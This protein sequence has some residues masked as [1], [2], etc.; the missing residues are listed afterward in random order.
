MALER[1]DETH[2]LRAIE[3]AHQSRANGNHPFGAL[4]VAASARVVVEAENTALTE[5]VTGHAEL[6]VVRAASKQLDFASMEGAT[7]YASTEPCAMCSGAIYWSGV[8]RV[9][10]A[11]SAET[12]MTFVNDLSGSATLA[13]PCREIFARGGR[14]VEVS[15]PHLVDQASAVHK[16]YWS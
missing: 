4:L 2:L 16:G 10:Y 9:V 1:A 5:D 14:S 13:L 8:G 12:M 6:K 7:L 15:G 3:L 11:L